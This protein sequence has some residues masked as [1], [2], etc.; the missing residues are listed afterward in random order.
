MWKIY[1][2]LDDKW[3]RYGQFEDRTDARHFA[4]YLCQ[5]LGELNEDF[6]LVVTESDDP[7]MVLN[8]MD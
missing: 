7:A 2:N 1:A 4:E 3:S 8:E 6:E 5:W